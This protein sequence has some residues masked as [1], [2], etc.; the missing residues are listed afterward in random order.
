MF[1]ILQVN[2]VAYGFEDKDHLLETATLFGR[3]LRMNVRSGGRDVLEQIMMHMPKEQFVHPNI[4]LESRNAVMH[5]LMF[6]A[7]V[8]DPQKRSE[9]RALL[10][11]PEPDED[12]VISRQ[13]IREQL[14]Q[15]ETSGIIE[16]NIDPEHVGRFWSYFNYTH[17]LCKR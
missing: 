4:E 2:P 11:I 10:N 15:S 13:M 8:T 1:D 7:A 17:E 9:V 14:H 6:N 12:S 3:L 5:F 16:L